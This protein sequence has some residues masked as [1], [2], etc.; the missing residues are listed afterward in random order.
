M[1]KKKDNRLARVLILY[2]QGTPEDPDEGAHEDFREIIMD[3]ATDYKV[4]RAGT[5][6]GEIV[7]YLNDWW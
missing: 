6:T 1:R 2:V 3:A 7:E 5:D 4:F